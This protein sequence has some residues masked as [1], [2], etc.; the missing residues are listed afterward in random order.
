MIASAVTDKITLLMPLL[1]NNPRL[2]AVNDEE[3]IINPVQEHTYD[4]YQY[5]YYYR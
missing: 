4:N 5:C 3:S 1:L 2:I